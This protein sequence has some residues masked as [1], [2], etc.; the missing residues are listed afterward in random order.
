MRTLKESILSSTKTG[1]KAFCT[2]FPKSRFEL[3]K[4]IR[5]EIMEKGNNCSLNH[6][7]VSKITD[8]STL[9]FNSNFNGDISDWDV[10]NVEDMYGMFRGAKFF[11]GD[12][13]KWNVS[14]VIDMSYMFNKSVFNGEISKWNVGNVTDMSYMFF[15]SKFNNDISNWNVSNV[16][17]MWSMFDNSNFNQD[18]SNWEINPKCDIGDMFRNCNIKDEY[19]PKKDGK[20]IK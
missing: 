7:D 10:S 5:S 9:F 12:I 15:N 16:E 2:L 1:K 4:M 6:I 20:I 13:S 14:K 19:K 3:L 18:I 11:N 17:H 8:M